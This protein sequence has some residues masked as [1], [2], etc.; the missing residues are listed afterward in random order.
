MPKP[1]E[2]VPI[3]GW[4]TLIHKLGL[5]T[6]PMLRRHR[7]QPA[8]G[9]KPVACYWS[10]HAYVVLYRAEDAVD[11]PALSPGRQRRYDEARTCAEC[12]KKSLET[13]GKG[14]DDKRY[15]SA[16]QEPVHE[17]MW[18]AERA[19]DRPVVAEWARGVL[20]DP[21]TVLVAAASETYWQTV[22]AV[23]AAGRSEYVGRVRHYDLGPDPSHPMY[24]EL[25]EIPTPS[26]FA[27]GLADHRVVSWW[28]STAPRRDGLGLTFGADGDY[29]GH[30]YDRWVGRLAGQRASY[31]HLPRL[32]S[33]RPPAG[34][35]AEQVV[36]MRALLDEMAADAPPVVV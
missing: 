31:R 14:L 28:A 30:W 11:M 27:D 24:A 18:L 23:N 10:G 17:R 4:E 32:H 12:G 33:H 20:A 21:R 6:V 36:V 16:C 7:R 2:G 8:D 5:A 26:G 22:V 15:C 35:P 25:L 29:L 1:P 19:A 9:Q 34:S 13:M 3:Y